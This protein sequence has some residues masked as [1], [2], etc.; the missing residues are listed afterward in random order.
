MVCLG[1]YDQTQEQINNCFMLRQQQWPS[2]EK[3]VSS[4]IDS[5]F[6]GR[7]PKGLFVKFN[8]QAINLGKQSQAES[9]DGRFFHSVCFASVN[10]PASTERDTVKVNNTKKLLRIRKL[11]LVLFMNK[12]SVFFCLFQPNMLYMCLWCIT[13][14]LFCRWSHWLHVSGVMSCVFS[15][16]LHNP[17]TVASP[18]AHLC[19]QDHG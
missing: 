9:Q 19:L 4:L 2:V 6:R 11:W 5:L 1:D 8:D 14:F 17:W 10:T 7:A 15:S 16:I 3:E 12:S 13:P 18:S